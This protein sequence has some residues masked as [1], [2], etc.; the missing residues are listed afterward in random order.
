MTKFGIL[1][2][3]A[4]TIT[5]GFVTDEIKRRHSAVNRR[6]KA[7]FHVVGT[8]VG[9]S[10][11]PLGRDKSASITENFLARFIVKKIIKRIASGFVRTIFPRIGRSGINNC[12]APCV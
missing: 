4:S 7:G 8:I 2:R 1:V 12:N 6:N 11:A 3:K 10:E 9:I 5:H